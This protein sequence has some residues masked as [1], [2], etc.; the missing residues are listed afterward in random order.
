MNLFKI[1]NL[2]KEHRSHVLVALTSWL[3]LRTPSSGRVYWISSFEDEEE[4]VL[5]WRW[6]DKHPPRV[7]TDPREPSLPS[8]QGRLALHLSCFADQV[9][10]CVISALLFWVQ[11]AAGLHS[12]CL[13]PKESVLY[14]KNKKISHYSLKT[15]SQPLYLFTACQGLG[16]RGQLGFLLR[17]SA[18]M[19]EPTWPLALGPSVWT[20]S[21]HV[22]LSQNSVLVCVLLDVVQDGPIHDPPTLANLL[23]TP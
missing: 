11:C 15:K 10:E 17:V 18:E 9:A 12:V 4:C 21:P 7:L 1:T 14:Q 8:S 23:S 3:L 6:G 13:C 22:L 19:K 20:I 16:E 5:G 2:P